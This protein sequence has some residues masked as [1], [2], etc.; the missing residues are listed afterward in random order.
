MG[1]EDQEDLSPLGLFLSL[2]KGFC[3][4]LSW[5]SE[6]SFLLCGFPSMH[7]LWAWAVVTLHGCGSHGT[8][9][10]GIQGP[11]IPRPGWR[12]LGFLFFSKVTHSSGQHYSCHLLPD[13][14]LWE[15]RQAWSW[16]CFQ[17]WHRAWPKECREHYPTQQSR[18]LK[19]RGESI[20]LRSHST[21]GLQTLIC[22]FIHSAHVY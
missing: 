14:H 19:S 12:T 8:Q 4:F 3:S 20:C 17:P 2:G 13:Q 9:Q 10:E 21:S 16:S 5:A 1:K 22:S 7:H 15:G 18:R 6:I 11:E